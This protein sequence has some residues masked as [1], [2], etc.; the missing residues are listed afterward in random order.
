MLKLQRG[1]HH[2][3]NHFRFGQKIDITKH[4]YFFCIFINSTIFA[5]ENKDNQ[6]KSLYRNF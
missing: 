3:I 2:Y 6:H 4:A 1:E 5:S